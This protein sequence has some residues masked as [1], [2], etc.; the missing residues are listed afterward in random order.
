MGD[1]IVYVFEEAFGQYR[2][3]DKLGVENRFRIVRKL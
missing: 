2:S 3:S 1:A